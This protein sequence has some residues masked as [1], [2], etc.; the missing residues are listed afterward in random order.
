MF[1]DYPKDCPV[2][3]LDRRLAALGR[4]DID[5]DLST[6]ERGVWTQIDAN[7]RGGLAPLP[8]RLAAGVCALV[9]LAASAAGATAATIQASPPPQSAFA[10]E[11]PLA[12]STALGG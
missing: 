3:D 4:V 5:R 10:V 12:P 8:A 6:L 1:Q 9:A 2:R 11:A 7:A